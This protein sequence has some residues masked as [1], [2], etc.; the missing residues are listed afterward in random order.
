MRSARW[1]VF[2]LFAGAVIAAMIILDP[3]ARL[4]GTSDLEAVTPRDRSELSVVTL[5][6]TNEAN[7]QL[8][9]ADS[10]PVIAGSGG[11]VTTVIEPGVAIT[12]GLNLYA[13]NGAPTVAIPGDVP[14]WRTLRDDDVGADVAQLEAG[15]VALG[16]DPDGTMTVDDTFTT[17]TEAV[18]ERWQE[19][20]GLPVTGAVSLGSVV[21]L[22]EGSIVSSVDAAIGQEINTGTSMLTLAST[23]RLVQAQIGADL[24]ASIDIGETISAR[25]PDRTNLQATVTDIAVAGDGVWQVSAALADTD[26]ELPSGDAIPVDVT[27]TEVVAADVTTVRANALT[28]LDSGA[29]VVEVVD[30]DD[31]T[32]FVEVGIG[33]RSGSTV[34]LLTDLEPGTV[35]IAP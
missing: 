14:A 31:S 28:R 19:D 18:V 8:I 7:G 22:P 11:T 32:R 12:T 21:F 29:Y 17:T 35:V 15:L 24:L 2:V 25:L 30:A 1:F 13:V 6:T 26:D 20:V 33:R 27:W 16:Y 4:G 5:S 9:V 23:Q 34:E 10:R 3:L